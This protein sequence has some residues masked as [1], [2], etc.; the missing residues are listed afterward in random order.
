MAYS[1]P[2]NFIYIESKHYYVHQSQKLYTSNVDIWYTSNL[3]TS[4]ILNLNITIHI[5]S[6]HTYNIF[7][8]IPP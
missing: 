2:G 6:R 4:Y 3:V 7:L 1:K 8:N 5:K